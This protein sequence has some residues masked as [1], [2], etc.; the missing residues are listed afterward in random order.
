MENILRVVLSSFLVVGLIYFILNNAV[1]TSNYKVK[2]LAFII[3]GV[4]IFIATLIGFLYDLKMGK[5]MDFEYFIFPIMN[6]L[7]MSIYTIYFFTSSKK[8][9]HKIGNY[10]NRIDTK[11]H[12]YLYVLISFDN[13]LYLDRDI[14][15]SKFKNEIPKTK[16]KGLKIKFDKGVYFHDEMIT[17]FIEET[18]LKTYSVNL[19]GQADI[20]GKKY[21]EVF[22]YNVV[23][24]EKTPFLDTLSKVSKYDIMNCD[25]EDNDKKIILNMLVSKNFEI[26][27]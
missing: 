2:G 13:D 3:T 17:K 24:F 19:V 26:K 21:Q 18:G 1:S 25:M 27:M 6:I 22:C 4:I 14:I 8:Y 7:Q 23:V 11:V 5:Y 9:H 16:Y 15:K 12:K 10:K 20:Q